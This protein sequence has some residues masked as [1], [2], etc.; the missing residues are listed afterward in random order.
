MDQH[1]KRS[2]C[3]LCG[4]EFSK[5]ELRKNLVL[6]RLLDGKSPVSMPVNVFSLFT[7][8]FLLSTFLL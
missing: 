2:R 5:D 7:F 1:S 3:P 4:T 8:N 6:N